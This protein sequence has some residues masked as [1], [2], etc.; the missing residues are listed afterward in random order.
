[1]KTSVT[2][3][4]QTVIPSPIRKRYNIRD[5]DKLIWIDDGVSIRI[6]PVSANP[7]EALRGLARG[8]NLLEQLLADR[9]EERSRER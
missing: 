3:R 4:G 9:Q 1:M 5:G 2:R 7:V 6:I 8:E